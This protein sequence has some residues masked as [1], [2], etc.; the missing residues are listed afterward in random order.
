MSL[1]VNPTGP[2]RTKDGFKNQEEIKVYVLSLYD[3]TPQIERWIV[4]VNEPRIFRVRAVYDAVMASSGYKGRKL[5]SL[6]LSW[7]HVTHVVFTAKANIEALLDRVIREG[8]CVVTHLELCFGP[9]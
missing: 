7:N 9:P 4:T 8:L 3:N 6:G 1:H 5:L 2:A